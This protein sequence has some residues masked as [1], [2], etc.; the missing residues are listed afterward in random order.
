MA[1]HSGA[2]A[3]DLADVLRA[4]LAGA[5]PELF[6]MVPPAVVLTVSGE[7][8][9]FPRASTA[10]P[11]VS[12]SEPRSAEP[13]GSA[14]RVVRQSST[15]EGVVRILTGTGGATLTLSG[16]VARVRRAR[17]LAMALLLTDADRIVAGARSTVNE[18]VYT[19]SQQL[20]A[21]VVTGVDTH[22]A[23]DAATVT[24]TLY[25][26]AVLELSR[27]LREGE[28]SVRAVPVPTSNPT[29]TSYEY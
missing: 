20:T 2:R 4:Q 12:P 22:L 7:S 6:G 26:E 25:L 21:L 5:S 15:P 3:A 1:D 14:T 29:S 27:P 28:D 17:D 24:I 11:A 16:T 9:A 19:T 8:L 13:D 18:G 23:G 10:E